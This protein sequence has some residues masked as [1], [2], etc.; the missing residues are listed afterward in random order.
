VKEPFRIA[1]SLLRPCNSLKMIQI[2]TRN[3]LIYAPFVP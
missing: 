1:V 2:T 3:A